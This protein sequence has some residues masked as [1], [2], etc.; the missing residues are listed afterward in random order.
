MKQFGKSTL[1]LII[2]AVLT[3]GTV[4]A[5]AQAPGGEPQSWTRKHWN[6]LKA[7]FEKEK[8][9]W[10]DCRKQNKEQKLRGKKSWAFLYSCMKK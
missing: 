6:E 7:G 3:V 10:A 5:L 8:D 2:A 4:G 9:K 1:P